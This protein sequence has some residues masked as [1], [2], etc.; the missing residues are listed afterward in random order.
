[1]DP[2]GITAA[3]PLHH[4]LATLFDGC[5]LGA[6]L[7]RVSRFFVLLSKAHPPRKD[8][9][10]CRER[11]WR[12]LEFVPAADR[13]ESWFKLA[14][15]QRLAEGALAGSRMRDAITRPSTKPAPCAIHAM[16]E[17]PIDAIQMSKPT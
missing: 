16:P 14:R 17:S 9:A 12:E 5:E 13:D 7:D 11:A 15:N 2:A 6:F 4:L 3:G 8:G 1:M 10:F